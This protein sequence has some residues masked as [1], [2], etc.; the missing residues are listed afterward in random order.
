MFILMACWCDGGPPRK[1]N[2]GR[3]AAAIAAKRGGAPPPPKSAK[4]G[5]SSGLADNLSFSI[6]AS[7]SLFAFA[8][9]FWNQILTWKQNDRGLQLR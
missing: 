3:V 8:R 7:C 4:E 1:L 2:W 9:R 6:S 5:G